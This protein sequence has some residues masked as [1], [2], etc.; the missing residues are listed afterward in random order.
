M[1]KKEDYGRLARMTW[2]FHQGSR[3]FLGGVIYTIYSTL[4][5]IVSRFFVDMETW[6]WETFVYTVLGNGMVGLGISN[7]IDKLRDMVSP[8][9]VTYAKIEAKEKGID[10]E[11]E[12][13]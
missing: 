5:L 3:N 1:K 6:E 12:G 8:A 13:K 2:D 4:F 7:G 10:L 11:D 9:S